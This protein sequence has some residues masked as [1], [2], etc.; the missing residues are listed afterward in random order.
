MAMETM[1]VGCI[2]AAEKTVFCG[3]WALGGET[4]LYLN[5]DE[6]LDDGC[7]FGEGETHLHG[8]GVLGKRRSDGGGEYDDKG[9][10][11][12]HLERKE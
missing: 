9:C 3:A 8:R 11:G 6:G 12:E 10:C 2:A 7:F 5:S 1:R 4:G